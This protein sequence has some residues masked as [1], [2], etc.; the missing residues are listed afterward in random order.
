MQILDLLDQ[1]QLLMLHMDNQVL[2]NTTQL[3]K[4][5]F[6]SKCVLQNATSAINKEK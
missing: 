4:T 3:Q 5:N 6:T 1:L 2:L